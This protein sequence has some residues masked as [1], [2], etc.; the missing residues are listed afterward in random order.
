MIAISR[1]I[2]YNYS[3]I[4]NEKQLYTD[5]LD[6]EIDYCDLDPEKICDNCMKCLLTSD[7]NAVIIEKIIVKE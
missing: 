7:Y 4:D 6:S 5:D 1:H 2:L 3:M